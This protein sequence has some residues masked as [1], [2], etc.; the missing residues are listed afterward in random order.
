MNDKDRYNNIINKNKINYKNKKKN[1]K[2]NKKY[3]IEK[4]KKKC[5]K[6]KLVD[7]NN[8]HKIFNLISDLINNKNEINQIIPIN[9]KNQFIHKNNNYVNI[10][11]FILKDLKANDIENDFENHKISLDNDF[12]IDINKNYDII[13]TNIN[14]IDDLINIAKLYNPDKNNNYPFD[15]KKLNNIIKPLTELKNIIG[16]ND[17]K[18]NIVNQILYFLQNFDNNHM[19]H[20]VIQGPPG[21][22]KTHLGI[23]LSK[24]YYN[25]GIIKGSNNKQFIN[26]ING[27]KQNFNFKIIKRSDL[28]GQYLGHTA[29]KT[30]KVIDEC[31]GGVLFID[32]AY[33]LG[34]VNN[35]DNYSKECIDTLN[36]NLSENCSNFIC[37]IAGYSDKLDKCFFSHNEGLRRRFP[38]VYNINKYDYNELTN[39]FIKKVNDSNWKLD[40]TLFSKKNNIYSFIKNNYVKFKYFGGDIDIFFMNC[41][42]CHSVRIFGKNPKLRKILNYSDIENGFYKFISHRNKTEEQINQIAYMYS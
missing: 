39:I 3:E 4:I 31:E 41:K 28:I 7:S 42:L 16:M 5:N 12:T 22:G 30:Q 8:N 32:E 10:L 20:T 27:E 15:L 40:N 17:V 33:S 14:N 38:F 6:T 9:K 29:I 21:V 19:L 24:I 13:E 36:Q 37:I 26:P 34:N 23:I 18:K 1:F 11:D 2:Y 25:L 35:K